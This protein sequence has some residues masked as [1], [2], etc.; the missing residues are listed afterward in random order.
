MSCKV[1][2]RSILNI[3]TSCQTFAWNN[4]KLWNIK[5]IAIAFCSRKGNIRDALYLPLRKSNQKSNL[6]LR[7]KLLQSMMI[8]GILQAALSYF[9]KCVFTDKYKRCCE[10]LRTFR[11]CSWE[12]KDLTAICQQLHLSLGKVW[13]L[14]TYCQHFQCTVNLSVEN[15]NL[16]LRYI[17]SSIHLVF[18]KKLAIIIC[19]VSCMPKVNAIF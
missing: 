19:V 18:N 1:V 5:L 9:N 14:L 8:K 4:N 17:L 11:L 15:G 2:A 3:I 16:I 6:H 12:Q 10:V 13:A 7:K